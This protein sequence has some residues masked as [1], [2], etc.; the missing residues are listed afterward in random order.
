[1]PAALRLMCVLAHP[2]DESLGTGGALAHYAQAG[3]ETHVVTAT[4][5]SGADTG[6]GVS[7]PGPRSSAGPVRPSSA[8]P[9]PY[10]A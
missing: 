8:P 10:W 5:A 1:M 2:D 9:P 6:I 7:I 4:R 3:I